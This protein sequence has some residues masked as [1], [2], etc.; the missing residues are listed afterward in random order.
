MRS[1]ASSARR[2]IEASGH[3]LDALKVVLGKDLIH[4]RAFV[5]RR[6]L[7]SAFRRH[8]HLLHP[9]KSRALGLSEEA[10]AH[11]FRELKQAYDDLLALLDDRTIIVLPQQRHSDVS[12]RREVRETRQRTPRSSRFSRAARCVHHVGGGLNVGDAIPK[13][14]LRFAQYLYYARIIDWETVLLAMRWQFQ[15][16]PRVGQIARQ[17]G[18]LTLEDVCHVL[19]HMRLGERF[20]EA[21][22][23]LGRINA[24]RLLIVLGLQ[25][26]L[27]HPIGRY[28]IEREIL[29]QNELHDLLDRHRNHNLSV[30]ADELRVRG[31]RGRASARSRVVWNQARSA[32]P[33]AL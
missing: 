13:R 10:L 18:Y 33:K 8:A 20:G 28:F 26:R 27:G 30:I 1:V 3:V 6:L 23:R 5:D 25:Q 4:N 7:K 31:R 12:W 15:R 17:I 11:Q 24:A 16:R 29:T 14:R 21:A 2:R 19:H 9:D 22:L 32:R